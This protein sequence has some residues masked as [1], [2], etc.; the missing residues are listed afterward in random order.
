LDPAA[1]DTGKLIVVICQAAPH[2]RRPHLTRGRNRT[3]PGTALHR[4][5]DPNQLVLAFAGLI[6]AAAVAMLRRVRRKW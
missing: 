2:H 3:R 5:I 1:L 6:V 4:H